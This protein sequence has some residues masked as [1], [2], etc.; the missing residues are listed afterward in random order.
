[1]VIEVKSKFIPK[2]QRSPY[3]GDRMQLAASMKLAERHF[4][5]VKGG[6]VSYKNRSFYVRWN[7]FLKRE[8]LKTIQLMERAEEGEQLKV[9]AKKISVFL[10]CT[11][12]VFVK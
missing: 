12:T 6:Y 8:L 9:H 1:M 7:W 4:G 2:N 11:G 10:V 3:P 5:R